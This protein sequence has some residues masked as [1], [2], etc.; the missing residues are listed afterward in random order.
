METHTLLTKY[1]VFKDVP[2]GGTFICNGNVCTKTSTR[3]A[4]LIDYGVTFYFKQN[5]VCKIEEGGVAGIVKR[6]EG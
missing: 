4:R 3:T 6:G 2:I 1:V 5:S